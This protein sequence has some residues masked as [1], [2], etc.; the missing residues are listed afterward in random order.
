[1][2]VVA[3]F[4]SDRKNK[5][6]PIEWVNGLNLSEL[7]NEAVN[8]SLVYT[9]FYSLNLSTKANFDL[10]MHDIFDGQDGCYKVH[11]LRFFGKIF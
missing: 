9:V 8:P 2:Y 6:L 3:H 1:M 10:P 11:L 4:V 5:C 7:R